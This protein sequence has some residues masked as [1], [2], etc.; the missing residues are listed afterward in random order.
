MVQKS[1]TIYIDSIEKPSSTHPYIHIYFTACGPQKLFEYKT[2][3]DV[4]NR[5]AQHI[6]QFKRPD[7]R[8][9]IAAL[10]YIYIYIYI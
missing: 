3:Q 10:L 8:S 2:C 1:L 4:K 9:L 6:R 5:Y 7:T